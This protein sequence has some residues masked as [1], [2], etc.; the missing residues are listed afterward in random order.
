MREVKINRPQYDPVSG[1]SLGLHESIGYLVVRGNQNVQ[2]P[3]HGFCKKISK[4]LYLFKSGGLQTTY[5]N[6]YYFLPSTTDRSEGINRHLG[7]V[8]LS[9]IDIPENS[10]ETRSN[11]SFDPSKLDIYC[12][13]KQVMTDAVVKMLRKVTDYLILI[14]F[15]MQMDFSQRNCLMLMLSGSVK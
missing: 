5:S 9:P 7:S 4:I 12:P 2:F 6:V 1:R 10:F 13:E 8:N 11:I 14:S 3:D 15:A